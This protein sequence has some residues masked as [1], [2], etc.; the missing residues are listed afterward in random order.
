MKKSQKKSAKSRDSESENPAIPGV[1]PAAP[2]HV[3]PEHSLPFQIVGIGSSA[4]G[5]EALIQLFGAM[6]VD[7]GMAFVVVQ[8]L[9]PTHDSTL[10]EI[11]ARATPLHVQAA[12]HHTHVQPNCVYVIPPDKNMV[13]GDG[14]LQLS[15]RTEVRGQ[16]R[17]IDHFLRSL[18]EEQ[19][20]KSI[21]VILS[22]MGSDGSLGLEEL[23]AAG[24]ITFAQDSSAAHRSM[25]RTAIATGCVDMVLSP[26]EIAREIG[27]IA[28]HPLLV[29]PQTVEAAA[30]HN[31]F[32]QIIGTLRD[33]VGVD[34][35]NYKRNTLHRRILRRMVLHKYEDPQ[36]Y[37]DYVKTHPNEAEALY[38]DILI[39][40]TSFFR[41]AEAYELLKTRVFPELTA[42]RSRKE[43]VRIWALG[44]STGE[45]A[46]SIA[47][48][49]TEFADANSVRTPLQIFATDLNGAGIEKARSGIYTKGIEQDVS[50]ERLRRFFSEI[51]GSYRISKPIRDMC[52]FARQNVL[53]DPPFSRMDLVA[54]RNVLIYLEPVL[55]KRLIPLLHYALRN[56][57][58]LWL[59]TSETIGAYR[60]LFEPLD[61]KYKLYSK[62]PGGTRPHIVF[63]RPHLGATAVPTRALPHRD[64]TI[65]EHNR[66]ADR[67][68]LAR[69]SPPAVVLTRDLEILQYR[70]DTGPYLAPA[71]GKA[72]LNLLKML[73]QGLAPAVSRAVEEAARKHAP[74][75]EDGLRVRSNGG[76]REVAIEV[77]PIR[78]VSGEETLLLLFHDRH[79]HPAHAA[80]PSAAETPVAD[81]EAQQEIERLR[82]ELTSTRD[83]LQS[84]IEQQDAYN[85]EL[86]SAN[87]EVQSANEEL[88]STNEE[89]E[90]SK[91]EIQSSA[92]E[93]ETIN[94]ELHSRNL[95]LSRANND[96][97]N[98]IGSTHLPIVIVGRDLRIRRLTPA[99]EKS[100][101]LIPSD[102][103]RPLGDIKLSIEIADLEALLR[104]VIDTMKTHEREVQDNEGRWVLVRI[105]PYKTV[106]NTID[107]A[108]LILIDID[109][110]MRAASALR[111]SEARFAAL[112]NSAPV[113]IWVSG[114][115]GLEYANRTA[116]EFFGVDEEQVK[117]YTWE[118][119]IH[120][121]D[122]AAY[123]RTYQEHYAAREPFETQIR[124]RRADGAYR[125]MKSVALPRLADGDFLG[126][127]A[128]CVE[129]EDLK[130]AEEALHEA[131]SLKNRFI[132]VLG[133]ELRNPLAAVRNSVEAINLSKRDGNVLPR[134]LD[135][136]ERQTA[137]M[138]RIVDDLLDISR[139]T[140]GLLMLHKARIDIV[141]CVRQAVE[142]TE[143]MR[144]A[145]GQSM[146]ADLPEQ[147]IW[148]DADPVR[149]EQ[150][151]G[152]L[153]VNASKFTNAGGNIRVIVAAS[154]GTKPAPPGST[155]FVSIRIID[156]GIGMNPTLLGR[157]FE[158]FVQGDAAS[159]SRSTGMGLG[160]PL[161]K[162]LVELH[163]GTIRA[164]SEG[165]GKGLEI[166]ICLPIP[167]T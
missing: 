149:L 127:V 25:P 36:H 7:T 58:F 128:S 3:D 116:A 164:T 105:R 77:V 143:H 144:K 84:V 125:W 78:N 79:E 137:N 2:D 45:E 62:K 159:S 53:A 115:E 75:R 80:K 52:V 121:D 26:S 65:A 118:R 117:R 73:R 122:R 147:P 113:L 132:A 157:I 138:V 42:N 29:D 160:L 9:D 130:H 114:P 34:F 5:I 126:Y 74:V 146:H 87:E 89:L 101:N 40:V 44:C 142:A 20:Y 28:Q 10:V 82:N 107:G 6:N 83:Y 11:I 54:C 47:M 106:E 63:D 39:N 167:K 64:A 22:G 152:N 120:P 81:S 67:I 97:L 151:F 123:V 153:L 95:E 35:S 21:A 13:L 109:S 102:V 56:H 66:E 162:Q 46:Y 4:G 150:L 48:A 27:R 1:N 43:P 18:A 14:M 163:G 94:D 108:V 76:Y 161:T 88:Q 155:A 104:G 60:D 112:A 158:L 156:D 32:E 165:E 145:S 57:G 103:G 99:A 12:G 100:L 71:A 70:G 72:S 111:E 33:I 134:A 41:D 96:L 37:A 135:V 141:A 91:E 90:T 86:Q 140:H 30:G 92:E 55:Q 31:V 15:P 148:V 93:L 38:E 61:A 17:P 85:E 124:L 154:S 23:K 139:I 98:L 49:Y 136:I 59:G 131:D 110:A 51:D 16:H 133:H 50:P 166:E 129:I 24:G 68:L 69:Y 19:G 8:H 119:Y